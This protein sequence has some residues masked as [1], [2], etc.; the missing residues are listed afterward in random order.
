MPPMQEA[1]VSIAMV[2]VIKGEEIVHDGNRRIAHRGDCR[3]KVERTAEL[4]IKD[5]AGGQDVAGR[6]ISG[7]R[8]RAAR[9]VV[10]LVDGD[11][12]AKHP[13]VADEIRGGCQSAEAA[14]DYVRHHRLLPSAELMGARDPVR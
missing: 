2:A 4:R 1:A 3:E 12:L 11:I 9:S 6:H 14:T 8:E 7:Q 10:G 5:R 13:R